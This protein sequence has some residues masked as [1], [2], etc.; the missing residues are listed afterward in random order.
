MPIYMD[1]HDVSVEV[2]AE[3]VAA[4]H[5]ADLK[6]QDKY[7]CRGITY[8]FDDVRKTAF[9]LIEAPNKLAIQRMHDNAHGEVP[10]HI[11]EVDGRI[12]ESFLGRIEDPKK[13]TNTKLNII[14]DPAFRTILYLEL[15]YPILNGTETNWLQRHISTVCDELTNFEGRLVTQH[16]TSL[17]ASFNN[18]SNAVNYTLAIQKKIKTS[19]TTFDKTLIKVHMGMSA[20]TPVTHSNGFFI[21]TIKTA[22]RFCKAS[23]DTIIISSEIKDLYESEHID[24]RLTNPTINVLNT[25]DEQFLNALYDYIDAHWENP[26][27]EV[28]DF[29]LNLG[30]SKSQ[31]YRKMMA[32]IGKSPNAFLKEYRLKKALALLQLETF[33][34]TEIA[35]KTGFNSGAYFSKCF[36]NHFKIL[37]SAYLK[38]ENIMPSKIS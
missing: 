8:W 17:L 37:P 7:N 16:K 3:I 32:L 18:V 25:K 24:N 27:L 21:D 14:N 1:R 28:K 2:T 6:I 33:S 4:L 5:Q 38:Q 11:I 31:F 20:G 26:M 36:F 35:F 23:D 30:Y 9:C 15:S 12:V 34:I 19:Y 10:H 29:C 22:K 13:S